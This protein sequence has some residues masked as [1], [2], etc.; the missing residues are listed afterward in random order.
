M[1][2]APRVAA[3]GVNFVVP[4]ALMWRSEKE[5]PYTS[6]VQCHSGLTAL[7]LTLAVQTGVCAEFD[8]RRIFVESF[9]VHTWTLRFKLT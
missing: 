2:L 7:G 1:C 9:A 6:P 8:S 5:K 3:R 4:V